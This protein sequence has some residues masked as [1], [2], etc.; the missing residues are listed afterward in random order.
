M[1]IFRCAQM[2]L[3]KFTPIPVLNPKILLKMPIPHLCLS[4]YLSLGWME[5]GEIARTWR[6]KGGRKREA[7]FDAAPLHFIFEEVI[8]IWRTWGK[9]TH[10]YFTTF[11]WP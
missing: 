5:E 1:K 9:N 11:Y 6:M 4:G 7:L 3:S 2:R 10:Y 8:K